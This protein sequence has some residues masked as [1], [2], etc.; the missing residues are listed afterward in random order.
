MFH[1]KDFFGTLMPDDE[2]FVSPTQKFGQVVVVEM[3]R[4][5]RFELLN[6]LLSKL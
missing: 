1:D 3:V 6:L 2:N 4:F 5:F